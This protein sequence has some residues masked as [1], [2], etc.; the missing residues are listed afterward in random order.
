MHAL[1]SH[2]EHA[3]EV[4]AASLEE[5][6]HIGGYCEVPVDERPDLFAC[7][8]VHRNV[9]GAAATATPPTTAT[10][11]T[12]R[13]LPDNCA[14][15]IVTD[16][17]R[18]WFVGPPTRADLPRLTAGEVAYGLRLRTAAIE[19]VTGCAADLTDTDAGLE[20][21]FGSRTARELIERIPLGPA[22]V[23]EVLR[24]RWASHPVDERARRAVAALTHPTRDRIGSVATEL[25]WSPRHFRRL[26]E[27]ATGLSPKTIHRVARLHRFLASAEGSRQPLARAAAQAGYADQSHLGREVRALAGISPAALLS[28]RSR[29]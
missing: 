23:G 20:D 28:E 15:I 27:Q 29:R 3:T 5:N 4:A 13:I 24:R 11:T 14:D 17:G 2:A 26:V 25:S 1:C 6:G 8:W 21:L 12:P 16:R 9:P 7:W 18:S 19:A 22:A 10:R